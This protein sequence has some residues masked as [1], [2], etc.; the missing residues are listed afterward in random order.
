MR[1]NYDFAEARQGAVLATP[2]KTR[3]TIHLD[4][5]VLEA[6]RRAAGARGCGYQTL[7]NATLRDA[8]LGIGT[9][10]RGA[11]GV[12]EDSAAYGPFAELERNLVRE[13]R[14]VARQFEARGGSARGVRREPRSRKGKPTPR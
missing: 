13:V 5:E 10:E 11:A 8:M 7:I 9:A 2:G 4:T 1:S 6:F 12:R 14:N 3:I